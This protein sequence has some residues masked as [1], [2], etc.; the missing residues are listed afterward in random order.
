[1]SVKV[2]HTKIFLWA[3]MSL[4]LS[5]QRLH[6]SPDIQDV[7]GRLDG[8]QTARIRGTGF[9]TRGDYHA[10]P[11]KMIRMFDDFNDGNLLQN[12]FSNW[13]FAAGNG[14]VQYH[15]EDPR[16]SRHE[17]AYYRRTN[18][19]LGSI[20]ITGGNREEYYSSFYMRLSDG[21]NLTDA[22]SGTHQFKIIR[23]WSSNNK[24]NFYPAIGVPDGF[25][26]MIENVTPGVM[27]FQLQMD[28]IPDRPAGWHKM[29]VY[30]KKSSRPGAKDGK[31]QVW[32][33][34][35]LVFD[36]ATQFKDP[37]Y[38]NPNAPAY[39]VSGDFE[40]NNGNLSGEWNIGNYFSS[41]S[42]ST[43][44]DFDD[45]Y[46]D[47]T[48]ARVEVGNAGRYENCSIVET[49]IPV[50]W[51]DRS[52]EF[53]VN[54]GAFPSGSLAFL[55]V[56][57]KEGRVNSVGYPITFGT[58]GG[59]GGGSG[60]VPLVSI[61]SPSEDSSYALKSP[62]DTVSLSGTA[63][64][65]AGISRVTWQTDQGETGTA[66]GQ[67]KWKAPLIP[68]VKGDNV[69]VV[70]AE[71]EQGNIG[72]SV[73][74]ITVPRT[75]SISGNGEVGEDPGGLKPTQRFLRPGSPHNTARI[76]FGDKARDVSIHDYKGDM[77]FQIS[78]S[79][80]GPIVWE[81]QDSRGNI[82]ESGVYICHIRGE[83]GQSVYHAVTVVK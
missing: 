75:A 42:N 73:I 59:G 53:K 83:G 66:E 4:F 77:V 34:N 24:I 20:F 80:S 12:P 28:G 49:Q 38:N 2:F 65:N 18:A 5:A 41:A 70:R 74:N 50:E 33:D 8:G 68:V 40:T 13:V 6:A 25:H 21:F 54:S 52:I 16:T 27:R 57:D 55:Y 36:W 44:A 63:A 26:L 32:W 35:R 3:F 31:C 81:G 61:T 56:F 82:V 9:G 62:V 1:M 23:L 15:R 51:S 60:A 72:T 67:E 46:L 69:V 17:D 64:S 78:K 48:L 37:R 10:D 71:D 58:A 11:D 7:S 39:P 79:G 14:A 19:E 47:H 43:W 45:I 29:A 76:I 22:R 30:Y